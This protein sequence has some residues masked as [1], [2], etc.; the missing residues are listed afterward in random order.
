[1]RVVTGSD[2]FIVGSP[3]PL[4]IHTSRVPLS[5]VGG[6]GLAATRSGTPLLNICAWDESGDPSADWAAADDASPL[7][8]S[9]WTG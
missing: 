4:L 1:V 6:H 3:E 9:L 5:R 2:D 8:R 7:F